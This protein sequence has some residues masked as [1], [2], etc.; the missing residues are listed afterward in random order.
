MTVTK[1]PSIEIESVIL[2]VLVSPLV[3]VLRRASGALGLAND[4]LFQKPKDT[5]RGQMLERLY[6]Q[7]PFTSTGVI[8]ST[9]DSSTLSQFSI[10]PRERL[11]RRSSHSESDE[12]TNGLELSPRAAAA[13]II[14]YTESILLACRTF[15]DMSVYNLWEEVE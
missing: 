14:I 4:E 13:A 6:R 9:S 11:P 5:Y 3:A 15:S 8:G 10:S 7:Y 12:Y 1:M 2:P